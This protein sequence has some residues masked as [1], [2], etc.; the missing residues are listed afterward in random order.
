MLGAAGVA[1]H[2]TPAPPTKVMNPPFGFLVIILA[3]NVATLAR[4]AHATPA[5]QDLDQRLV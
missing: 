3:L 5:D 1:G 2:V 4:L